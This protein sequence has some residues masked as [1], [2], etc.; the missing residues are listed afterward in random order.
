MPII[1][2]RYILIF[3]QAAIFEVVATVQDNQ[4]IVVVFGVDGLVTF[5][6]LEVEVILD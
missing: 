3:D 1:A 4:I 5:L 2:S 6:G